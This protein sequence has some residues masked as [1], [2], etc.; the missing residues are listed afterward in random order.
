[1]FKQYLEKGII[2]IPERNGVPIKG[3][4]FSKFF[5]GSIKPTEAELESWNKEKNIGYGLLTGLPSGVIGIDIDIEIDE[6]KLKSLNNLL[7]NTPCIKRGTKGYTLF[8]AYN[9]EKTESYKNEKG[10]VV[11][12]LST[13]RK[14]TIPPSAIPY[15]KKK[16]LVEEGKELTNEYIWINEKLLK[17][18]LPQINENYKEII[19]AQFNLKE[20]DQ[21]DRHEYKKQYIHKRPYD[22]LEHTEIEEILAYIP[23]FEDYHSWKM[24]GACLYNE[25]GD[26]GLSLF[27]DYSRGSTKYKP[28]ELMQH[29]KGC[30]TFSQYSIGTL[31]Y[32]AKERG[33]KPTFKERIEYTAEEVED[34][35]KFDLQAVAKRA[36]MEREANDFPDW[37]HEAPPMV[38]QISDW[39]IN[40]ALFPQPIITMG[41]VIAFLGYAFGKEFVFEGTKGNMYNINLSRTGHGKDHIIKCLRG[42]AKAIGIKDTIG[43]G[44]VTSDT[45]IYE[46]INKHDGK[47]MYMIDEIQGFI[48]VICASSGNAR[49]SGISGVLLEAFNADQLQSV[50]KANEKESPTRIIERPYISLMGFCTPEPFYDAVSSNDANTGFLGRLSIFKG[51]LILPQRSK[52]YN[53]EAPYNPPYEIVEKIKNIRSKRQK[54]IT[55]DGL[56]VFADK[57]QIKASNEA[58]KL[59]EEIALEIDQKRRDTEISS[60]FSTSN[61]LGRSFEI[62]KKYMIVAS[63]CDTIEVEHVL[64]AKKVMDYNIGMMF[65]LASNM[66]ENT[67]DRVKRD[68]V[69]FIRLR[70]GA[71][72]KSK[73]TMGFRKFRDRREK[74]DVI[75]DL[76]EGEILKE[77]REK[78][79]GHK[80]KTMYVLNEE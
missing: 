63:E 56:E 57:T 79:K 65:N 27:D 7:G 70:G 47:R 80:P 64:W 44:K 26:A 21:Q 12:V 61:L 78:G 74:Q 16:K 17:V 32:L 6:K 33:Y 11:E 9:G 23:S 31:I 72:E 14:T 25:L 50:E 51:E 35:K 75:N 30:S 42:L 67:Y 73:A 39:I 4:L 8:F 59:C 54:A 41:S 43:N 10:V 40:S 52:S 46:K 71:I 45:S 18:I 55:F 76:L 29:W 3:C 19:F 24:V 15:T 20:E 68:F 48:K 53:P 38:K 2:V 37:Y 34:I 5:D 58:K 69:D 60:D 28:R 66:T 62:S 22:R 49:E 77:V 1:M 36:E 13:R